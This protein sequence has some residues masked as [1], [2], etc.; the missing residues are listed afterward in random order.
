MSGT[1][2]SGNNP[3]AFVPGVKKW[4]GMSYGKFPVQYTKL[5]DEDTSMRSYE[6]I[7]ETTGFGYVPVKNSGDS[8]VYDS[9]GQGVSTRVTHVAYS[10][11]YIVTREEMDDNQYQYFKNR[12]N[13]LAFSARSTKEVV[14]ANVYNR[15]FDSS[16]TFGDGKELLATD[17]PTFNGT[18][19]NELATPADLSEAALED[20]CI[21]IGKTKDTKGLNIPLIAESLIV[22]VDNMFE[23]ERIVKSVLQSDTS[24]NAINALKATNMFPKGVIV[25]NYLTDSD[26][27]YVRTNIPE[28]TGLLSI[29]RTKAEFQNDNEFDTSNFKQKFYE[30]YSVTCGDFRAIY[31]SAG[32]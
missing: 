16:Y 28:G 29:Q 11:G 9:Q 12:T 18:Q 4:W 22:P 30:R 25:N 10:L 19:S 17:H 2:T 23:A 14:H 31:G 21:L 32:A 20:L 3:K 1:I 6:E 26:A 15:A 7:I 5:F 24:N 27:F 13:A 8:V